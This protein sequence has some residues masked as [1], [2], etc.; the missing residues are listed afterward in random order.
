EL[1]KMTNSKLTVLWVPDN[2]Y[3]AK[4]DLVLASGELP[5]VI[6][7]N[8]YNKPNLVNAINQGAFWDLTAML[9]YFS[10]YSNLWGDMRP[11]SWQYVKYDGKIMGIPRSRASIDQG[12]MVRKEWMTKLNIPTPTT[13]DEFTDALRKISKSDPDGNGKNDTI[14]LIANDPFVNAIVPAFG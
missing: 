1:Q 3:E 10:E 11:G 12:I 6:M 14:P 4:F 9:G 2:E 8:D 13:M 7:E 5:D